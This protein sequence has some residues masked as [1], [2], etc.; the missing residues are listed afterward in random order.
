MSQ[1]GVLGS[2]KLIVNVTKVP[3]ECGAIR[4][5]Q[6]DVWFF[7]FLFFPCIH[8]LNSHYQSCEGIWRHSHT[9]GRHA[10]VFFL[11]LSCSLLFTCIPCSLFVSLHT[12]L[13]FTLLKLQRNVAPTHCN[14]FAPLQHTATHSHSTGRRMIFFS[15][16]SFIHLLFFPSCCS[17]HTLLKSTLPKLRKNM[18]PFALNRST[19]FFLNFPSFSFITFVF[20]PFFSLAY[21]T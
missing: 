2:E 13:K 5:Q 1:V 7:L 6:G 17:L 4:T 21:I 3:E 9:T 19:Y 8:Y 20:N 14:T 12:V 10:M 11:L 16:I 18:V 15:F